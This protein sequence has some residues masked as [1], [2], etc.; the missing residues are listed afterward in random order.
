M[1]FLNHVKEYMEDE[2]HKA[3]ILDTIKRLYDCY[4]EMAK[5][6]WNTW[7]N[8]EVTW[9]D[10][11]TTYVLKN[12]IGLMTSGMAYNVPKMTEEYI[13]RC[14]AAEPRKHL[15]F[16][17]Y[18]M[19]HTLQIFPE[20]YSWTKYGDNEYIQVGFGVYMSSYFPYPYAKEIEEYV[21]GL[22]RKE[23][24][25]ELNRLDS[26]INKFEE[27]VTEY[28]KYI[29]EH[30]KKIEEFRQK[31]SFDNLGD[32]E[33]KAMINHWFL[34]HDDKEVQTLLRNMGNRN[35]TLLLLVLDTKSNLA[36]YRNMS[37]RLENMFQT[38]LVP[39]TYME[40]L[41]VAEK[42]KQE[43]VDAAFEA[44][45][46]Y[47]PKYFEKKIGSGRKTSDVLSTS[48]IEQLLGN[49]NTSN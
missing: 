12:L 22:Y 11:E 31:Y 1:D 15:K 4:R 44:V 13:D 46:K 43:E 20:G 30:T 39:M 26:N 2:Q 14:I 42:S 34:V 49:L 38:E 41:T 37:R 25:D 47:D 5:N 10:T 19:K 29:G 48:E 24:A 17:Y 8:R 45:I 18:L 23:Y 35:I 40:Y 3:Q 6:Y 33:K 7:D 16:Q 9:E 28:K 21:N 27:S 36:L 32:P